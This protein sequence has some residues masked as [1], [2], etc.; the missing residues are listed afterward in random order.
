MW[1]F[2]FYVSSTSLI[3]PIRKR[4]RGVES[5]IPSIAFPTTDQA[6][7]HKVCPVHH[8]FASCP[9][10]SA[11]FISRSLKNTH[12]SHNS[13]IYRQL[14][15]PEGDCFPP[16]LE[17]IGSLRVLSSKQL[18][19][20][21]TRLRIQTLTPTMPTREPP[22]QRQLGRQEGLAMQPN[23]KSLLISGAGTMIRCRVSSGGLGISF[24]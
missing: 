20:L 7:V 17:R 14:N 4:P 24:I 21:D 8:A 11:H 15:H 9:S 18:S 6:R 19:P 12:P 3:T 13:P 1:R 2:F 16:C 22:R 10:P 23:L 5:F